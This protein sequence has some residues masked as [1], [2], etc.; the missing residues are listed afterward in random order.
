MVLSAWFDHLEKS[1]SYKE[2]QFKTFYPPVK[3]TCP[4][5]E[6]V[7]ENP[8][9][10]IKKWEDSQCNEPKWLAHGAH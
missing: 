1:F 2:V 10:G 4:S 6:N 8:E 7:N 9:G 5:S 3:I